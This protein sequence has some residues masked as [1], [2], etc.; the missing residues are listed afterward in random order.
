[1]GVPIHKVDIEQIRYEV[2]PFVRDAAALA[3]WSKRFFIDVATR[4]KVL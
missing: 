1:V 4:I 2:E 3:I